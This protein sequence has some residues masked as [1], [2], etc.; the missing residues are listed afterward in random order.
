MIGC[1]G[2]SREAVAIE[3]RQSESAVSLDWR[4]PHRINKLLSPAMPLAIGRGSASR[5]GDSR[6]AG[7]GPPG[8]RD[9]SALASAMRGLRYDGEIIT[10]DVV[11]AREIVPTPIIEQA[12]MERAEGQALLDQRRTIDAVAAFTRAVLND[13]EDAASY[14]GLGRALHRA[15]RAREACVAFRSNLAREPNSISVGEALV[16]S[17]QSSDDLEEA[18]TQCAELLARVPEHPFARGRRAVLLYYLE[19][20]AGAWI[21]VHAAETAGQA[22]P[23][24]LRPLLAERMEE[25]L[26]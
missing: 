13:L 21:E 9:A 3:P 26:R 1:R 16:L 14:D 24:Q 15:G 22:V 6:S 11:L 4:C 5:F 8:E 20:Y 10:E 12:Q 23:P 7:A 19:D 17:A 18:A 2:E 25:P